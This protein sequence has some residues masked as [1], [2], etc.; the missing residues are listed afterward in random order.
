MIIIHQFQ[1][2]SQKAVAD[3]EPLRFPNR[4]YGNQP[5]LHWLELKLVNT[6]HGHLKGLRFR[7][8]NR[9]Q[10]KNKRGDRKAAM[11][12]AEN[13]ARELDEKRKKEERMRRKLAELRGEAV[14]KEERSLSG[15]LSVGGGGKML[16]LK[17]KESGEHNAYVEKLNDGKEKDGKEKKDQESDE[18][19]DS[20]M[21]EQT[22]GSASGP[23]PLESQGG[24][25]E[26]ALV[27][28]KRKP[29]EKFLPMA[30][31]LARSFELM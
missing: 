21:K 24:A 19:K 11:M 30:I 14:V 1:V 6:P 2:M 17:D 29:R 9:P 15:S 7:D 26:V 10:T 18:G 31:W 5:P 12:R 28:R 3:L 27:L 22:K 13:T 4:I 20:E 16:M 8:H 25:A 23:K